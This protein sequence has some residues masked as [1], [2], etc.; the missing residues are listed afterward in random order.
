MSPVDSP[1]LETVVSDMAKDVSSAVPKQDKHRIRILFLRIMIA[2][3][4]CLL[5][6]FI[7]RVAAPRPASG[8]LDGCL[9]TPDGAALTASVRVN[10]QPGVVGPDGCF[11]FAS[12]PAGAQILVVQLPGGDWQQAVKILPGQA[13]SL[14]NVV[15]AISKGQP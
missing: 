1:S 7:Y 13:I 8:G 4:L 14:G 11:F 12:L 15:V 5:A 2:L 9:R 6:V 10:N 3:C